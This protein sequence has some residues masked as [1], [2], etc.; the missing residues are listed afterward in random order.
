MGLHDATPTYGTPVYG[1][2]KFTSAMSGGALAVTGDLSSDAGTIEAWAKTSTSGNGNQVV[3]GSS[4]SGIWIGQNNLGN[5]IFGRPGGAGASTVPIA[6]GQWHHLALVVTGTTFTLY[7]DG[8]S[9][10]SQSYTSAMSLPD[11]AGI[12][13]YGP[14]K[15]FPYTGQIDEVRISNVVRYSAAF[16]PPTQAFARDANTV[17]LFHLDEDGTDSAGDQTRFAPNHANIV[18]SPG[19][20]DVTATRAKTINPGAR[21][22]LCI[23]GGVTGVQLAFDISGNVAPAPILKYR[24]DELGWK[25]VPLVANV[26]IP[27]PTSNTWPSHTLEVVVQS[28]SEFV[29]RWT[30]Q[31]AHV[32][33]TGVLVAAGATVPTLAPMSKADRTLL[34]FGDSIVEGYKNLSNVTTPDGSDAEQGWAYQL[35]RYLGAEVGVIG[36]GG[37]KYVGTGQGGVPKLAESFALQW[38]G[39]PARSLSALA[40]DV[41]LISLGHNNQNQ[42][43]ATVYPEVLA[44]LQAMLAASS[45]KTTIIAMRPFIGMHAQT[46]QDA[47]TAIG[48][49]RVQYMDTAGFGGNTSVDMLD[50]T[51]PTGYASTRS[52]APKV[53]AAVRKVMNARL[54]TNVAGVAVPSAVQRL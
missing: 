40:P 21:F 47:V 11:S 25:V 20:W 2:G 22:R 23:D 27:L 24:I 42:D 17:A 32:S 6:D 3:F 54:F 7:V 38:G 43:Y 51:H 41:I 18:Y 16:T 49:R 14:V 29:T 45:P 35:G 44:C 1:T 53:A 9:A 39:G 36:F 30:P 8:V 26:T 12:G 52:I 37:T 19:N 15:S 31:Q 34:V 10:V 13:I 48:S 50:G 33:L 28:T 4:A 46:I 5:A